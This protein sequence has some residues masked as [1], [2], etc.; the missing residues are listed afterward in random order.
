MCVY[1]GSVGGL[2]GGGAEVVVI[3][4]IASLSVFWYCI[5]IG[6]IEY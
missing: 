4:S 5:I 1:V 2:G 3:S 6:Y